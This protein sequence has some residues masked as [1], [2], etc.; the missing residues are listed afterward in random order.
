MRCVPH[1]GYLAH[2]NNKGETSYKLDLINTKDL[3]P[4]LPEEE[5]FRLLSQ[6]KFPKHYRNINTTVF[7]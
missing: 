1:I 4:N 7:C 5:V 2:V 3:T 6:C